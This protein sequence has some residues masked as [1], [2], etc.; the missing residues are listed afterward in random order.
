MADE[1]RDLILKTIQTECHSPQNA[2]Q[3]AAGDPAWG[4]PLVGFSSGAD[5]VYASFKQAVGPFHWTPPEAFALAFPEIQATAA[6]LTVAAWILPQTEATKAD[7]RLERVYPA[8]RWARARMFG[9]KFNAYLRRQVVAA[10]ASR[11]YAAVAPGIAPQWA[12]HPSEAYTV[13]STWSERHVAYAS[14][15]GTFGLCDGLIT[16][17]GKAVRL[18][19]IVVRGQVT[20]TVRPYTHPRAYCLYFSEGT[21]GECISRCPV[22]ALSPAGHDKVKCRRHLDRTKPYIR[23]HYAFDG[24]ACGLCQTG[25]PCESGVPLPNPPNRLPN[26]Q[27]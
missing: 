23:E 26:A 25:V 6:E 10:L 7:N 18:G 19:S 24:Y 5:A 8:E 20:P 22:R 17:K 14:G 2:L 27:S 16:P 21:C 12:E 4:E 3:N 15:L 9:E 13:A 11:G 1:L